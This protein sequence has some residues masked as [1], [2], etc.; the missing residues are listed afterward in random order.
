MDTSAWILH[1]RPFK[2]NCLL[3]D[4]LTQSSGKITGI[5]YK[6]KKTNEASLQPF[7]EIYT[8]W[9]G[10]RELKNLQKIEVIKPF[11]LQANNLLA[12][13]YVNEL[14]VKIL[15]PAC[16]LSEVW[17]LYS[18]LIHNLSI[19][20][21][22]N[23]LLRIFEKNLLQALG[24]ALPLTHD[25]LSG[26][27][28]HPEL[29]YCFKWNEGFVQCDTSSSM[30]RAIPGWLLLQYHHNEMTSEIEPTVKYINQYALQSLL[31]TKSLNS[32]IFFQKKAK[33]VLPL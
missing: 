13:L 1:V 15:H 25:A 5:T 26:Q 17:L 21:P 4:L 31:G 20:T 22:L 18:D 23:K 33:R 19:K 30:Q 3:V 8:S 2:E 16:P 9:K 14:L 28:I 12:G 24:Y 6:K 10:E 11:F 32:R 7:N 27:P 29:H